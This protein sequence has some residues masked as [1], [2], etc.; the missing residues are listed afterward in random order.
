LVPAVTLL[1]K[2][3]FH[4]RHGTGVLIV[5]P[6]RETAVQVSGF[7]SELL[8]G[9]AYTVGMLI[10]GANRG[11]EVQKLERGINLL[12][13]T[14]ARLL[15]HF[16]ETTAFVFKNLKAFCV[17]GAEQFS[18][19]RDLKG[20]ISFLPKSRI[21][22]VLGT[23]KTDELEGLSEL[24]CRPDSVFRHTA[25]LPGTDGAPKEPQ[26]YVLVD[27]DK[28]LLLLYSFLKKFQR[29]KT[30]VLMSSTPSATFYSE[31]LNTLELPVHTIHGRQNAKAQAAAFSEFAKDENGTLII[32]EEAA[33][34]L[35]V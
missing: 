10:E 28:R 29:K 18:D 34:G 3:H 5:T 33:E 19:S 2:H 30:A 1:E 22:A 11:S 17:Y 20:I 31:L 35:E 12:V 16:R 4:S 32:T 21:S 13:A 23:E 7:A 6:S 9:T 27:A 24:I 25:E 15:E 14:P 8:S 26:G